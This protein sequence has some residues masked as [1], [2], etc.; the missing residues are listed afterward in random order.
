MPELDA[1]QNQIET[2]DDLRS[3]ALVAWKEARGEGPSGISAVM[4]VIKNRIGRAG[5][6][7]TLHDC[8]YGKNQFSSMS[9]PGDPQFNL[10]PKA[11][12]TLYAA[13]LAEAESILAG[14][15][16]DITKG[17]VYY[18]NLANIEK[19]GWFERNVLANP[20]KYPVMAR[21]GRHTF[22]GMVNPPNRPAIAK[23][24]VA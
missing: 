14:E 24:K 17:A 8:I 9:V 7:K 21:I 22:F 20:E 5:F 15:G 2:D 16:D 11:N 18:A 10:K 1:Q 12:D 23:R 13:C 3:L 6:G 19:G 4:H